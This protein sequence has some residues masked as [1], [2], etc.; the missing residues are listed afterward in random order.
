MG[1][2]VG[3]HRALIYDIGLLLYDWSSSIYRKYIKPTF[4]GPLFGLDSQLEGV[5]ELVYTGSECIFTMP[6][7]TYIQICFLCS[8]F[9]CFIY[10]VMEV[11]NEN[12]VI[13]IP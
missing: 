3:P 11:N 13:V 2:V 10:F 12:T 8:F 1:L 5:S 9:S 6:I 4:S 7:H